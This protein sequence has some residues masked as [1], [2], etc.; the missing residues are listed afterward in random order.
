[1][2]D[3]GGH[4]FELA[5]VDEVSDAEIAAKLEIEAGQVFIAAHVGPADVG[6]I[7]HKFFLPEEHD[8]IVTHKADSNF[9]KRFL[10]ANRAAGNFAYANRLYILSEAREAF[11]QAFG[12]EITVSVFSDAPHD[13]LDQTAPEGTNIFAHR[14]GVVRTRP[15][16]AYANDHPF[17]KTGR[18]FYFPSSLG[19]DAFIMARPDGDPQNFGVCSHGVGRSMTRDEAMNTYSDEELERQINETRIRL[20]RYGHG[21]FSAQAPAAHKDTDKILSLLDQFRLCRQVARLRPLA[22]LKS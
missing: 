6:L 9:A 13:L 8:K 1:V 10:M 4:F 21:G 3:G 18:P 17:G 5:V 15:S 22:S 19:E 12:R 14:K 7:A 16:G 11:C 20:Y 2:L